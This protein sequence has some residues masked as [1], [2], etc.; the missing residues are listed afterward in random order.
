MK[1]TAREVLELISTDGLVRLAYY[2]GVRWIGIIPVSLCRHAWFRPRLID[3][4]LLAT[5][6][7]VLTSR[8]KQEDKRPLGRHQPKR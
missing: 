5:R 7:R 1:T 3:K 6:H 2:L 4:I 8:L